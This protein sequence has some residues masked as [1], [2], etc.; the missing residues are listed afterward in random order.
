MQIQTQFN[1][2]NN[3]INNGG[4]DKQV[5]GVVTNEETHFGE[6]YTYGLTVHAITKGVI[7]D[8]RQKSK[9]I[10]QYSITTSTGAIV[11][12]IIVRGKTM[13]D[14]VVRIVK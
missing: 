3:N 8:P 13:P 12:F 11:I 10:Q 2:V 6:D 7:V 4:N 9:K 14:G 5:M 1:N